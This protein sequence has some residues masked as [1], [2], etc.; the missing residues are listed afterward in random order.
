VFL[1]LN[2]LEI[3]A[4][5]MAFEKIVLAVAEGFVDKGEVAKFFRDN[6]GR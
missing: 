1:S 3:A 4:D 5:E 6:S 2:G